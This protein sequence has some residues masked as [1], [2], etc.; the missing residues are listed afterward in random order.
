LLHRV[1]EEQIREDFK[2]AEQQVL[3]YIDK[4]QDE[5]KKLLE[6]R[7]KHEL[8]A[9]EVVYY[10]KNIMKIYSPIYKK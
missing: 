1:I 7:E 5:F 10:L 6:K 8:E 9:P 4:F 2:Q 3:D